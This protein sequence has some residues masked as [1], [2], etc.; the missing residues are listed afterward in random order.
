MI[1]PDMIDE[2]DREIL[3]SRDGWRFAPGDYVIDMDSFPSQLLLVVSRAEDQGSLKMPY[4]NVRDAKTGEPFV[5]PS[6]K[7]SDAVNEME[8]IAMM[9]R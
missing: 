6:Y 5:R 8:V 9:A 3:A 4:F 7:L 1:A 2:V